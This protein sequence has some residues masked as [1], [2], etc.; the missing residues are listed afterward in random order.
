MLLFLIII[1]LT[2]GVRYKTLRKIVDPG[3]LLNTVLRSSGQTDIIKMHT[4]TLYDIFY[5]RQ[6]NK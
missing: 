6:I 3:D 5:R 1:S 2:C 4:T